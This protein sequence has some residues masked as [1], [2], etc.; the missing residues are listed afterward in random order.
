[1][2]S[3][4]CGKEPMEDIL[5]T[6]DGKKVAA[7]KGETLL[8]AAR[9]NGIDIPSLCHL[10]GLVPY[11]GCRLCLVELKQGN[12]SQLV[13]S[14]GYYVREGLVVETD[15]PRVRK[16]R[17]MLLELL[18]A[19][20]PNSEEIRNWAERYEVRETR[21]RRPFE[22]CILCGLCVRYCDEV[23]KGNCLGFTGRGVH[24]EVAWVP[25]TTY[26]EKCSQCMEECQKLCPTGVFPSNWGIADIRCEEAGCKIAEKIEK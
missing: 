20:M 24:R 14:C 19:S 1:M 6:I 9:S 7:N 25:L 5:L 16:V 22:Y 11:G 2:P 4:P 10:K 8:E 18:L 12:R 21:F 15:S 13:A 26:S 3:D 23:R 17:K